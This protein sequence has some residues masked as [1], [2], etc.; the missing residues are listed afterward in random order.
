MSFLPT[1]PKRSPRDKDY[2]N[3]DNGDDGVAKHN[4]NS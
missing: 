2:I 3:V 1:I 4:E